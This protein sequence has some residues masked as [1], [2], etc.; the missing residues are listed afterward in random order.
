MKR[1]ANSLPK[2]QTAGAA[3]HWSKYYHARA[4]KLHHIVERTVRR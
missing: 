4:K 2:R 1:P 3:S